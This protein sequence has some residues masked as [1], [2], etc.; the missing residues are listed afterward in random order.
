M[1]MAE[2]R[3]HDHYSFRN[4]IRAGC[5]Q[6]CWLVFNEMAKGADLEKVRRDL[7]NGVML[8][9]FA[10]STRMAL[11]KILRTRY[12][13][14]SDPWVHAELIRASRYGPDAPEF[15]S[16]LFLY[17]ILR[18]KLAFEF[19]VEIIWGKWLSHDLPICSGDVSAFYSQLSE[20]KN[21]FGKITAESKGKLIRNTVSTLQ[22]FGLVTG[23]KHRVITRPPVVTRT[24]FH[25]VRLLAHEGLSGKQIVE[26]PEW[27][28]F[29]WDQQDVSKMFARLA[30]E[31]L[32]RYERSGQVVILEIRKEPI[33]ESGA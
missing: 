28:I 22:D 14:I 24:A 27:R 32:I 15:I 11:W 30:Q 19:V 20:T 5:I 12:L 23:K 17:F 2:I 3:Q 18:D 6:E 1:K 21:I 7:A 31:K 13:N 4:T 10:Y 33:P 29:L 25:L 8:G 26:S 9:H 16:L